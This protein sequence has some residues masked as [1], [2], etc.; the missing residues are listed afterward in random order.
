MEGPELEVE[1]IVLPRRRLEAERQEDPEGRNFGL[2]RWSTEKKKKKKKKKKNPN[3]IPKNSE[4]DQPDPTWKMSNA[5][6]P[7][8]EGAFGSG[9]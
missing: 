6:D 4:I 3:A 9:L 5:A 8:V 7:A 2:G 1:E